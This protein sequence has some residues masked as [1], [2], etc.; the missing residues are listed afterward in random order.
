MT[1]PHPGRAI[2]GE[3][4]AAGSAPW[5]SRRGPPPGLLL[6]AGGWLAL[7]AMTTLA[8]Q[9]RVPFCDEVA[10]LDNTRLLER[11][12]LSQEF[13]RGMRGQAPGPLLNAV[14]AVAATLT[15]LEFP[16]VR[17]VHV[18]SLPLLLALLHRLIRP[19]RPAD[20]LSLT[21]ACSAVPMLWHV[22]GYVCSE[23]PTAIAVVA[24]I[25]LLL[26]GLGRLGPGDRPHGTSEAWAAVLVGGV[27][28]GLGILGRA[29]F[30]GPLACLPLM[31]RG[32]RDPRRDGLLLAGFAA[33]ALTVSIPVFVVWRGLVPPQQAFVG[34]GIAPWHLV[35][36][37]AYGFFLALLVAPAW[38]GLDRRMLAAMLVTVAVAFVLNLL[39]L[40]VTFRPLASLMPRLLPE[41]GLTL[42][43]H[44]M[45]AVLSG[46][47]M[48]ML[49]A[50]M[51][52]ARRHARDG[53][54]LFL[55]AAGF[56][57]LASA[58]K[59]THQYSSA[60]S[61]Q[62]LPFLALPLSVGSR[63]GRWDV[64]RIAGGMILGLAAHAAWMAALR[65]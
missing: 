7:L 47:G 62:A 38:L 10:F 24:G 18:L 46:L 55:L 42:Y 36:S 6:V 12:G 15:H 56:A 27:C 59:I 48:G 53:V 2:D 35:L 64:V 57:M 3:P 40:H 61:L 26:A 11:C 9:S 45:P 52:S 51:R 20:A 63:V 28:Y 21:L 50:G 17:V 54:M 16:W 43:D 8:P 5:A 58:V 41:A 60:Y 49:V 65:G 22:S 33:L 25:L 30:L 13:L 34:Q 39:W 29:T 19:W 32:S 4:S 37:L 1:T 23:Q 31:L 14:H 44:G